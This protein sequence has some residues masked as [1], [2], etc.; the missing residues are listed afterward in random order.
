MPDWDRFSDE[1]DPEPDLDRPTRAE[2]EAD[3]ADDG[4]PGP[5]PAWLASEERKEMLADVEWRTAEVN[6][7]EARDYRCCDLTP[8]GENP[9]E[10]WYDRHVE[11]WLRSEGHQEPC[12]AQ[13]RLG[14]VCCYRLGHDL[15]VFPH[16]Y[17]WSDDR[18]ESPQ[19]PL[20]GPQ[21]PGEDEAEYVGPCPLCGALVPPDAHAAGCPVGTAPDDLGSDF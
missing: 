8:P 9:D 15:S 11:A 5:D 10:G 2:A 14:R 17:V 4:P 7:C 18:L 12:T 20:E 6:T 19:E 1:Y 21:E 3:M 16:R 13:D